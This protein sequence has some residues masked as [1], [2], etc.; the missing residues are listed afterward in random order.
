M[1][2]VSSGGSAAPKP[3]HPAPGVVHA[4]NI[5]SHMASQHAATVVQ[6]IARTHNHGHATPAQV[7]TPHPDHA[8]AAAMHYLQ[9]ALAQEVAASM[10][11]PANQAPG[12]GPMMWNGQQWV[13]APV[14]PQGGQAVMG[15]GGVVGQQPSDAGNNS[16]ASSGGNGILA[17]LQSIM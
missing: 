12:N 5:V 1:F 4:Q 8:S 2:A 7:M 15:P 6:H 13:P 9:H 14:A 3:S 11:D 17:Y 10:Q 16:I